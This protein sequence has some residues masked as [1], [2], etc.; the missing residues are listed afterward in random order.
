[1][2]RARS[3]FSPSIT[4]ISSSISAISVSKLTS[5]WGLAALAGIVSLGFMGFPPSMLALLAGQSMHPR[6]GGH[7]RKLP[8]E[9]LELPPELASP[10]QH[11]R[12]NIRELRQ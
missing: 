10:R 11:E 9:Q 5:A 4:T 2:P 6:I 1:M 12:Q 3:S 7:C 8:L